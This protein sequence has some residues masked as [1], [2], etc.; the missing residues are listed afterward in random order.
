MPYD[1]ST[2]IL[3]APL[4]QADISLATGENSGDVGTLCS[5]TKVNPFAKFKPM[6]ATGILGQIPDSQRNMIQ[7]REGI[8]ITQYTDPEELIDGLDWQ[9]TRPTTI[10]RMADFVSSANPTT[11]GY[12]K[13][14]PVP[15]MCVV[16]P[17]G[18]QINSVNEL[19]DQNARVPFYAF[20]RTAVEIADKQVD[21]SNG[22]SSSSY[23]H[24]ANQLAAC[25]SAD[26]L[27]TYD[28][29]S[30]IGTDS[31]FGL[32]LFTERTSGGETTYTYIGTYLCKQPINTNSVYGTTF[33]AF[34][35]YANSALHF[36]TD[37]VEEMPTGT[38]WAVPCLKLDGGTFVRLARYP[39]ETGSIYPTW[40]QFGNGMTEFYECTFRFGTSSTAP[41]TKPVS[42]YLDSKSNGLYVY[43]YVRNTSPWPHQTTSQTFGNWTLTV[44]IRGLFNGTAGGN[45]VTFDRS[46]IATRVSPSSFTLAPGEEGVIVY[47]VGM[48]WSADGVNTLQSISEGAA[49][50]VGFNLAYSG[51]TLGHLDADGSAPVNEQTIYYR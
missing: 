31:R 25:I 50:F 8:R 24:S 3:T 36:E 45:P 39:F 33:D 46:V 15:L 40:F 23:G 28:G 17:G 11:I 49:L 22:I 34:C 21:N 37:D 27:A 9:A 18:W 48:L 6:E 19:A 32:A 4:N 51:T 7:V 35:L 10:Y 16:G 43:C 14:A 5:S 20:F 29:N 26:E 44:R 38:F 47:H 41:A 42:G 13:E 2:K 1:S 30:L 12:Y